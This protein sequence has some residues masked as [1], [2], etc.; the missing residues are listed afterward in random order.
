VPAQPVRILLPLSADERAAYA[1]AFHTFF[2]AFD[3]FT[4]MAPGAQ[5]AEFVRWARS[6]PAGRPGLLAWHRAL[7]ALAW[8][9]AKSAA[10]AA[11]LAAHAGARVLLFTADKESTYALARAHLV[12]PVT[13]ELPRRERQQLLAAFL[14]AELRA[15]VGPRLLDDGVPEACADVGVVVGSAFGRRQRLARERRIAAPG[16]VYELLSQDT[17]E[18][19]RARREV[20]IARTPAALD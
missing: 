10:V 11:I 2:G 18:V 17:V 7:A 13:A 16:V 6:D 19:G 15:L 14:R 5:F 9:R 12:A 4:A 3:H 20:A 8:T 1:D